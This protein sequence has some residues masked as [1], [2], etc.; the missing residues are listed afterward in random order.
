MIEYIKNNE[1]LL[2][3]IVRNSYKQEGLK[4]FTSEKATQQ[5]GCVGHQKG[6]VVD[7]HVHNMVKREVFY[8]SETL[9]IKQG[10]VRAD[11]Y[12]N[13]RKYIESK[14]LEQGDVILF[15]D[16]GHGFKFLEDCQMVEI[17]QGPYLDEQ[18]KVRFKGID[19][20][21]VVMK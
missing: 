16:G 7:A 10:K 21:Q 19:D 9:I 1:Q 11:I 17:K 15:T 5:I 18:D 2:A 4:F 8:T 6:L 13:D 12:D 20:T 3:I 14:V